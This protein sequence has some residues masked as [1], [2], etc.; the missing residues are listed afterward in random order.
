MHDI[1]HVLKPYGY[2][3]T[4]GIKPDIGIGGLVLSGGYGFLARNYGLT[5]D[6]LIEAE[7]VLADGSVVI[8][9]DDNEYSDLMWGLK[10]GGGN[11]GIVTKFVF[12]SFKLPP[13]CFGG[14]VSYLA[15]TMASA[16]AICHEFDN[17]IQ[18]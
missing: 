9:T 6:Q 2:A 12:Q 5:V 11:F 17:I 4:L 10:G 3:I 14:S 7:V 18:V 15:P 13:Y 16:R 1:D 8:A